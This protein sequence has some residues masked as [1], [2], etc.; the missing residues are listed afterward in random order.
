MRMDFF[1]GESTEQGQIDARIRL[2]GLRTD[3]L[4]RLFCCH[5]LVDWQIGTGL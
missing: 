4:P 1:N 3:V 2:V 5:N